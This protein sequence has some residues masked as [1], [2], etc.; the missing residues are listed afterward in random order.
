MFNAQ[1]CINP[2]LIK[3]MKF[4]KPVRKFNDIRSNL[5]RNIIVTFEKLC[6]AFFFVVLL[7]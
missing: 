4:Q 2:Q 7:S 3:Q 6:T 5:C 1:L